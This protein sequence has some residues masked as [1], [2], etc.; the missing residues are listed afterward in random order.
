MRGRRFVAMLT[1][2]A[3]RFGKPLVLQLASSGADIAITSLAPLEGLAVALRGNVK[4]RISLRVA[5]GAVRSTLGAVDL[6]VHVAPHELAVS[7]SG[8]YPC[9]E[10][11]AS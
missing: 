4:D 10:T 3:H 9:T 8:L 2:A 1:A 6:L 11:V 7:A 5:L